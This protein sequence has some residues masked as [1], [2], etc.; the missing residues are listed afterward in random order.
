MSSYNIIG[1]SY[2]RPDAPDKTTGKTKFITDINIKNM[3]YGHPIYSTIP[4]GKIRSIDISESEKVSSF[5]G[6]FFADDIPGE[7]QIGVILKDQP[8]FAAKI[9]RFIG[10][11]IGI[12]VAKN[13]SAA[14]QITEKIK[15]EYE[16]F[17]PYLS[18]DESKSAASN[19]IHNNNIA[20]EHK[21]IKGDINKGFA[22]SK[23]IVEADIKTPVQEHYYLEPQGCIAIPKSDGIEIHGSLQCPYYIQKGV[24][25]VLGVALNKVTVIQSPTGGAF[26]GKEDIPSE[27]A[28]RAAVA[29][30]RLQRPVKIIYNRHDDIQLTSKRHPFQMHYKVGVSGTGKLLA[31]E[32]ILE[33]G[34]G[35][36][37][38]LSSVVS[39]RSTMQAMGPYVIPNINVKSTSYYTNLPPNGAF[40]GFGSPQATFGHERIMDIIAS[41]IGIDPV[42]FRLKNVLRTGDATLT[43]HKLTAS[44]GAKETIVRAAKAARWDRRLKGAKEDERYLYGIG[45]SASHYGNC[46]GAAGWHMDGAGAT[47]QLNRDGTVSV[48]YGLIDMGQGAITVVT[49]MTAEALG[50]DPKRITVLPTDTRNVPDSGPSVASRNV[51]MTGNA[52]REVSHKILPILRSAAADMLNCVRDSIKIEND[53]ISN[54]MNVNVINFGDLI[55]FVYNNDPSY[56]LFNSVIHKDG[57]WHTPKLDFDAETGQGAAYFTYSYATH[58][59][60]VRI[61]K[62]TGLVKVEKLW[63]AHDVGKA[64]NPAGIE[65]QVE[66]GVAQG[67]GYALTEN[68]KIHNGKVLTDNLT[69]YLLPTALDMC[70]VETII[71]EDPEPLGPWGAKGIGEPAIIPTAAAIANAVS[72]AIGKSI[73]EIPITPEN[74]LDLLENH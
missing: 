13:E 34:A 12:A 68:F 57:W 1:K 27:L 59:A 64:I 69:T 47:I 23:Y 51:V 17:D 60:K 3:V 38:T 22:D 14:K 32:I 6:T 33:E 42:E 54:D 40:R 25:R 31:A 48:A 70:D 39:Y 45:I 67:I 21:S 36:Y 52:I 18:I 58:I 10:D 24:A 66:G 11:S 46:L 71:V 2:K 4:F 37:A 73:N 16:E 62:L 9:V 43:D 7:N 15:I 35:A 49:Q 61:D 19:F 53:I 56:R 63:A 72:N 29:A 74:V 65:A 50:I 8:L 55:D 28:A 26:G 44:V 20:C 30:L 41:K 5:C